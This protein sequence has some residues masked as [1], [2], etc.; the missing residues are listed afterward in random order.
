[1]GAGAPLKTDLYIQGL[2]S[3]GVAQTADHEGQF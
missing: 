1:M 2:G 3:G